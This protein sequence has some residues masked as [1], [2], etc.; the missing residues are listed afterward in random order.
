M[1]TLDNR[2]YYSFGSFGSRSTWHGCTED[3]ALFTVHTADSEH[4]ISCKV[5][6]STPSSFGCWR[7]G[8]CLQC[9]L[10][11]VYSVFTV[12]SAHCVHCTLCTVCSLCSQC[13]VHTAVLAHGGLGAGSSC[14]L[15]EPR[16]AAASAAPHSHST[17]RIHQSQPDFD[18]SNSTP[19]KVGSNWVSSS[20]FGYTSVKLQ[21][22]VSHSTRHI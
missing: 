17:L 12:Y 7:T 20:A 6:Y 9:T 18:S 14:C 13:T 3:L 21:T 8:H 22:T 11:T 16:A 2:V 19:P 4:L 15:A 5:C 10:F 1:C